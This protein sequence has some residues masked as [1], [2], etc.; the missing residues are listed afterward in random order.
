M[1]TVLVEA[2]AL[3]ICYGN[4]V[5]VSEASLVVRRGEQLSLVGRSGGGKTSLLLALAGLLKPTAGEVV[6]SG[7][8]PRQDLGVVFQAPSLLPELTALENVALPLRLRN[9]EAAAA[10]ERA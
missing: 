8:Q 6:W 9:V 5:V 3:S 2:R 4:Q 1:S 7:V 10:Y